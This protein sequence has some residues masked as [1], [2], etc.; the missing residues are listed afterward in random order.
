MI[1]L[2]KISVLEVTPAMRNAMLD[3]YNEILDA[4]LNTIDEE[5]EE[6]EEPE[7]PRLP[8]PGADSPDEVDRA[9]PPNRH[10]VNSTLGL[11]AFKR[12]S[13]LDE[14]YESSSGES[15]EERR[16]SK[17]KT[18]KT[19]RKLNPPAQP[20]KKNKRTNESDEESGE[21]PPKPK[22][23]K[24]LKTPAKTTNKRKRKQASDKESDEES[25]EEPLKKT[26]KL[27][28]PAKTT[29]E[30]EETSDAENPNINQVSPDKWNVLMEQGEPMTV[31][32][33]NVKKDKSK[34]TAK[35]TRRKKADESDFESEKE[36]EQESDE[37]SEEEYEKRKPKKSK[38]TAKPP[39]KKSK[40]KKP[41]KATMEAHLDREEF[42]R[43]MK[44]F[45]NT[46]DPWTEEEMRAC[47]IFH[48]CG[49]R[50]I[51]LS[52]VRTKCKEEGLRLSE[53]SMQRIYQKMKTIFQ[54]MK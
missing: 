13:I 15:D 43:R 37:E 26:K 14:D 16:P 2:S 25:G 24:N 46:S 33:P 45:R 27:K 3:M 7:T 34:K 5:G 4:P 1:S 53:S 23:T 49:H 6:D 42:I 10:S 19:T 36:S 47:E 30:D 51:Q 28:T 44:K 50:R 39:A 21:E 31:P 48:Y 29:S 9:R 41:S 11:S 40:P 12:R 8:D 18:P 17:T 22:K 38:K 32:L 20:T 54:N 52:D 35:T